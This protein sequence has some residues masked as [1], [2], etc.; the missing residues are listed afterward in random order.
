MRFRHGV[1]AVL[2]ISAF[3]FAAPAQAADGDLDPSF[4]TGGQTVFSLFPGVG[5][6]GAG[7]LLPAADG[8]FLAVGSGDGRQ[9]WV[10]KHDA[11][12]ALVPGYGNLPGGYFANLTDRSFSIGAVPTGDGGVLMVGGYDSPSSFSSMAI[13][14]TPA[15]LPDPSFGNDA[16]KPTGDGVVQYD[17]GGEDDFN[18]VAMQGNSAIVTGRIGP[19]GSLDILFLRLNA[20]GSIDPAFGPPGH[21]FDLPGDHQGEMIAPTSDGGFV[22]AMSGDDGASVLKVT[23]GGQIDTSFGG[24][25]GIATPPAGGQDNTAPSGIVVDPSGNILVAATFNGGGGGRFPAGPGGTDADPLRTTY[26]TRFLPN[27]TPDA[28]FGNGGTVTT[29]PDANGDRFGQSSLA[30]GDDGKI[31][32]AGSFRNTTAARTDPAVKRLLPNGSPDPSWGGTGLRIYPVAGSDFADV[33]GITLLPGRKILLAGSTSPDGA[34]D[35]LLMKLNG[36]TT[37]PETAITGGPKGK[38]SPRKRVSFGFAVVDDT[39]ATYECKLIRPKRKP[40]HH[41]A[42]K[43]APK[44]QF[45]PCTSPRAYGGFKRPGKYTFLVRATDPAGNVDVTPAKRTVRVKRHRH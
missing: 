11:A 29:V 40:R 21:K 25:D 26:L 4:G 43:P 41:K 42:G 15:G 9:P 20:D 34:S 2:T 17:L 16:P 23:A 3:A 37:A 6:E 22:I 31:L 27:G 8:S 44:P 33:G 12:G 19:F 24:G 13:K 10:S 14:L 35:R 1:L 39:S 5:S 36:D 45:T 32:I 7:Q 18:A 30:I 38:I 28:S